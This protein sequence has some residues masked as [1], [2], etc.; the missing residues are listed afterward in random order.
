MVVRIIWF[1]VLR[2]VLIDGRFFVYIYV[3]FWYVIC[4][5]ILSVGFILLVSDG[6]EIC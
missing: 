3:V 1:L 6:K 4:V 5:N 2:V